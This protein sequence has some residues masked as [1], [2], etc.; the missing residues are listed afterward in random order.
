MRE[1][2]PKRSGLPDTMRTIGALSTVGFS[3]VLAI[4]TYAMGRISHVHVH[5]A[6]SDGLFANLA[7]FQKAHAAFQRLAVAPVGFS[8]TA[9]TT[10]PT[11]A[12][13]LDGITAFS[14]GVDSCFSAYMHTELSAAT[15]KRPIRAALMMHG[16]DI[17]LD[18]TAEFARSA[19][20]SAELAREAGLKLFTGSTN[21]RVLP[22]LWERTFATNVAACLSFFQ[23]AYAFALIPSFHDYANTDLRHGSNPVTDP[24]LSSSSFQIV[25]D[26]AGY[27]R[28][29]KLRHLAEG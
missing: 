20:R 19:T 27:G 9:I 21:L 7:E 13:S 1:R 24:L 8:A 23:P 4:V 18:Q 3:F 6:V 12:R 15:P 22:V 16:F 11:G 2:S 28:I 26:G 14:G 5:G 25:H 17:P 29:D 10:P